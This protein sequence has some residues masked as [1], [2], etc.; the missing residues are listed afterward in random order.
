[1]FRKIFSLRNLINF[2]GRASIREYLITWVVALILMFVILSLDGLMSADE[3]D[4]NQQISSAVAWQIGLISLLNSI[5]LG[6][7]VLLIIAVTVRRMH[8]QDK[9]W[10]L[11]LIGLV[12]IIGQ[13]LH[14]LVVFTPGTVGENSYGPDPRGRDDPEPAY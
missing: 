3:I 6:L 8:D 1:M 11:M 4:T 5:G 7:S 13:I 2:R 14:L 9:P 12:P 10:Y